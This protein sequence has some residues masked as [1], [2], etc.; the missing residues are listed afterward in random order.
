MEIN[1][2]D[3]DLLLPNQGQDESSS[4]GYTSRQ[5]KQA[6]GRTRWTVVGG[7][8]GTLTVL[9]SLIFVTLSMDSNT[10]LLPLAL[11]S[12]IRHPFNNPEQDP[13]TMALDGTWKEGFSAKTFNEFF[14]NRMAT[15]RS[16][17]TRCR[18]N[19]DKLILLPWGHF[20]NYF[21]GVR[22]GENIWA[23]AL[24]DAMW[25]L[26]YSML[27]P[28]DDPDTYDLFRR[29]HQN[30][31]AIFWGDSPCLWNSSCVYAEDPL[32]IYPVPPPNST[33]L[34]IPL[35]KIFTLNFWNGP[36]GALGR[37][38]TLSPEPYHLWNT[39]RE[40]EGHNIYL[41]YSVERTCMK[42][43][44][45]PHSERPRQAYI[46]AKVLSYFQDTSY[47]LS[48]PSG[49]NATQ[50]TDDFYAKLAE[51]LDMTWIASFKLD[52]KP[53]GSKPP[54][55]ITKLERLDRPAFQR[56]LA[57]SRLV[58]GIGKPALSPTP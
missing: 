30:V 28:K 15:C 40:N 7:I 36:S 9:S 54:P 21:R 53:A 22:Q 24:M 20:S 17:K 16:G 1:D 57:E 10:T 44:S 3:S 43:P 35:W 25:G 5:S 33:H 26:G 31:H 47:I 27:L 23:D 55:G 12:P 56:K 37:P 58:L 39:Y 18:K 6:K 51:E 14:E 45:V 29:Y 38:F 2:T 34:N 32:S 19:W 11:D 50:L 48:D 8:I 13:V 4:F 52:A 41:G 49:N 46:L 42:T